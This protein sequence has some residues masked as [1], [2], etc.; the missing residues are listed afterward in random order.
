MTQKIRRARRSKAK[1]KDADAFKPGDKVTTDVTLQVGVV[2]SVEGSG[3]NA[4]VL[5]RFGKP[6]KHGV[7]DVRKLYAYL[8]RKNG[9]ASDALL[10][11]AV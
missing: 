5:I 1:A 6:D 9:K 2:L 10:P 7:S 4:K 3:D 11:V 8:L